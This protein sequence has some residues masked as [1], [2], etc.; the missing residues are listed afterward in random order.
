MEVNKAIEFL[1]EIYETRIYPRKYGKNSLMQ[2]IN[3]LK[4][5]EAEN[6][7]LK[8]YKAMWTELWEQTLDNEFYDHIGKLSE[9]MGE[10][11]EQY[12]ECDKPTLPEPVQKIADNQKIMDRLGGKE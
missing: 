6:K 8:P 11:E 4:S 7:R 12:L 2:I 5:L 10:L 1:N 3:L 9:C